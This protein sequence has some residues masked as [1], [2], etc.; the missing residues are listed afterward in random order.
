MRPI[1]SEFGLM[2]ARIEVEL[3]WIKSLAIN[4]QINEVPPLSEQ[5]IAHIDAI[6]DNF[7]E[8]DGK[9]IKAIEGT[10]NHDVKAIEYFI[11]EIRGQSR[12]PHHLEFVH[13]RT[14]EDIITSHTVSC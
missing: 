7:S 13:L 5:A 10:T 2:R 3:A 4:P 8:T 9:S 6:V 11:K 14:S 12:A 1:A